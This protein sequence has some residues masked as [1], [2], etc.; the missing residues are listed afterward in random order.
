MPGLNFGLSCGPR[1]V[2]KMLFQRSEKGKLIIYNFKNMSSFESKKIDA[3]STTSPACL[4]M[5]EP[6]AVLA[7]AVAELRQ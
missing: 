3:S 7:Y 6:V 1:W 2:L 5:H 4:F